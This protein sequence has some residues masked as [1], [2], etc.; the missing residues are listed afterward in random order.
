MGVSPLRRESFT[1]SSIQIESI[2][3]SA[4]PSSN[5][6]VGQVDDGSPGDRGRLGGDLV[7]K[8]VP[9]GWLLICLTAKGTSMQNDVKAEFRA[10]RA[11]TGGACV[12]VARVDDGILVRDG[13]DRRGPVL[14]FEDIEWMNFVGALRVGAVGS[15]GEN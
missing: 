6:M 15:A 3:R 9:L 13:K 7:I 10:A 1:R 4:E 12:E 14:S 5:R 11:C 8:W 2:F